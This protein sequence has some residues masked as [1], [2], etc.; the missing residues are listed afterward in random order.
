MSDNILDW[1]FSKEGEEKIAELS[2]EEMIDCLDEWDE[3]KK[4]W[5]RKKIGQAVDY[6]TTFWGQWIADPETRDEKS[7]TGKLFRRRFR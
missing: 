5:S 1:C 6:S 3:V 4:Y 7:R 2:F